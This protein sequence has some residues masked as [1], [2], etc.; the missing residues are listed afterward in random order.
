MQPGDRLDLDVL[1]P[2]AL[3]A[4]QQTPRCAVAIFL[5]HRHA[6]GKPVRQV[7]ALIGKC[8]ACAALPVCRE[9]LPLIAVD[10]RN[11]LVAKLQQQSDGAV[12]CPFIVDVEKGK[13]E[14][15]ALGAAMDDVGHAGFLQQPDAPVGRGG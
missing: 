15:E 4:G 1:Q 10:Q 13:I 3:Q 5:R 14:I 2:F 8:F 7:Q 9:C 12:K 6:A 11:P